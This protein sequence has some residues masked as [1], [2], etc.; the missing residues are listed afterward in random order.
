MTPCETME[1]ISAYREREK[2]AW[3]RTRQ[4]G[5]WIMNV[6][7][8]VVQRPVKPEN[9]I[10]F[11]EDIE[12]FRQEH[13]P[14]KRKREAMETFLFHK[15]KCWTKIGLNPDGEIHIFNQDDYDRLVRKNKK[16]N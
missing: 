1:V 8:K 7:G 11:E 6:A 9:L 15:E 13:D 16:E 2:E 12:R 4:L 5:A 3:K 14:E 10:W